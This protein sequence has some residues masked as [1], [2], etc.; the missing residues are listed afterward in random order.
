MRVLDTD[1]DAIAACLRRGLQAEVGD[2]LQPRRAGDEELVCF[3]L[4]LHHLV[5]RDAARTRELQAR[6]LRAW[7]GRAG[8]V[9]VN[10]YVYEAFVEPTLSGKLIYA[11]TSSR[12]LSWLAGAVARFV[13]S[14]RANTFGVGV[15]FRTGAEWEALFREAGYEVIGYRRGV[16]EE[17]SLARRLL[18]IRSCRRDSFVLRARPDA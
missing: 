5:G 1:R 7:A 18:L 17:V 4:I 9:F 2:A 10:E 8:R 12:A 15:R 11:V 13:P 14:L 16:D 6:A 3:N